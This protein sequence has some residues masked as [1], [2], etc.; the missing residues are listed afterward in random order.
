MELISSNF[1]VK[2]S[3]YLREANEQH[4]ATSGR[5]SHH[6]NEAEVK[7]FRSERKVKEGR[8][9]MSI[10]RNESEKAG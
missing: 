1:G 6:Q 5:S 8:K 7:V 3:V 4:G 9:G 2:V 10:K